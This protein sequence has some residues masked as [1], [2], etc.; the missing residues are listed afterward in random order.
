LLY[1]A[2]VFE[3]NKWYLFDIKYKWYTWYTIFCYN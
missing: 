1:E 2:I 3:K